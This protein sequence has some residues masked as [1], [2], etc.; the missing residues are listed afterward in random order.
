MA[1]VFVSITLTAPF[2]LL[3]AHTVLPSGATAMPSTRG[4]T[5]TSRT[6]VPFTRSIA[7]TAPAPM[8]DVNARAPSPAMATMC[9]PAGP[10]GITARSDRT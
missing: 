5:G 7:D 9:D 8:S 2:V 4:P 6:S 3:P 10:V 1:P